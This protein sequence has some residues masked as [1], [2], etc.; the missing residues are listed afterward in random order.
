MA[1]RWLKLFSGTTADADAGLHRVRRC[2]SG[3]SSTRGWCTTRFGTRDQR[4][5]RRRSACSPSWAS[6]CGKRSSRTDRAASHRAMTLDQKRWVI[7]G[8][9]LPLPLSLVCVQWLEVA[10]RQ[11]EAGL[12]QARVADAGRLAPVRRLPQPGATRAS[13]ITGPAARTPRRAWRAS[14]AT[15]PRRR[16]PTC[17]SHY[18]QQIA[19]VVTPRDCARCHPTEAAEFAASHHAKAG[20]ILA[21]LDNFLAETVEGSRVRL[22]PALA[23]ARQGRRRS[24]NGMASANSGCQQCHGSQGGACRRATAA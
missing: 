13:S 1:F 24:V 3:R 12:A 9:G 21:S 15:R 17:F 4:L 16:T 18:G 19:T 23:D 7:G 6:P 10:R 20:N 2:S 11:H 8:L 22:Q 14:T 5:D